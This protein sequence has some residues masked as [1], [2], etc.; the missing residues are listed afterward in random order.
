LLAGCLAVLALAVVYPTLR[1]LLRAF[2]QWD[3]S[4][5]LS[6]HG[7][8][9]V[10]NTVVISALTVVSSAVVGTGMALF[11]NRHTFPGRDTL[12]ALAY[13][14]LTLPPLVGVVAFYYL[15]GQD[16]FLPRAVEAATGAHGW[17]PRG[18]LAILLIH[19]YSFCVYF[20][21]MAGSA[22]Q[23][24]DSSQQEAA[25]TLGAGPLRVFTRVT[26]PALK[27][28]LLGASLLTFMSSGASFSAP[29]I[30]GNDYPM[31]TVLIYEKTSQAQEAQALTLTVVLGLV[32]LAGVLLFRS[33]AASA[34]GGVKGSPRPLRSGPARLGAAA[35][36]VLV[37]A[38]LLLPHL[39]I[40][41]L[42]FADHTSWHGELAPTSYTLANYAR[43][44]SDPRAFAPLRNSLW[45]SA[46]AAAAT[47][48]LALP[49]GYLIG[50]RRRGAA[51]VNALV[52]IPWA[53]PG[54][55]IAMNL[56]VAFNDPRVPAQALLWMLP[57]AYFVR[58]VPLLTRM[59]TAAI[60]PFDAGLIEAGRT[61]GASP[62]RCF[63]RLALPLIAPAVLAGTALVFALSLGEFVASILLYRP[64]NLPVA[65]MINMQLRGSGIGSAFAYSVFL[66]ALVTATFA[67][68]R[69]FSPRLL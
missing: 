15:I 55:V 16:G 51:W 28:A 52:M 59:C 9:A 46:V 47:L 30:F 43:I 26:L 11:L 12:A 40:L 65:V 61:L 42:S 31:L 54:T 20:Y 34:T 67:L 18:P 60:E 19:T 8:D 49:A 24:L 32:S 62:A 44:F 39:T 45:M 13:L 23:Q 3:P 6:G 1:L 10:R 64:S 56:I 5:V 41:W 27:P 63:T 38:L 17:Y 14:P 53:L 68:A 35:A 57:L 33:R 21:A 69:R 48:A 4:A 25:R 29:L 22:L 66:M 36:A 37:M 58:N 7:L 2:A 50:R